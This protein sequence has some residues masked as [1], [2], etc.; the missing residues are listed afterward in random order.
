MPD[1]SHEDLRGVRFE[2][3]EMTEARFRKVDLARARFE[4]VNMSG[5]VMRGA[6]LFDVDISGE[7]WNLTINGVDVGPW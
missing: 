4:Q 7:I 1:L 2:G 6:E 5:V 3:V